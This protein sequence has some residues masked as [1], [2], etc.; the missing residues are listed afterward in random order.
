MLLIQF[1]LKHIELVFLMVER[2][3]SREKEPS[4]EIVD[5]YSHSHEKEDE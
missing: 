2:L 5:P 1:T 4:Y 3:G